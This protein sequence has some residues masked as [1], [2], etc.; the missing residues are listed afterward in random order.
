MKK[1]FIIL[2]VLFMP[3]FVFA[4]T[5]TLTEAMLSDFNITINSAGNVKQAAIDFNSTSLAADVGTMGFHNYAGYLAITHG[6]YDRWII[7]GYK[8]LPGGNGTYQIGAA[9]DDVLGLK[10]LKFLVTKDL[11]LSNLIFTKGGDTAKIG[12]ESLA[13]DAEISLDADSAGFGTIQIGDNQ[14]FTQ[15]RF[16]TA[17]V[18]TL[19]NNTANV[20]NTDSDTDLCIYDAGDHVN[21]KNRLGSELTLRYDIKFGQN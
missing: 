8:F 11:Y 15:F 9:S 20:A 14:E 12:S 5:S 18:V 16:T 2:L 3:A 21:I 10:E 17:G 6:N 7:N 13:D 4:G 1:I 19:L